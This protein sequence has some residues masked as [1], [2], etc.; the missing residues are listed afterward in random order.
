MPVT[1]IVGAVLGA[2]MMALIIKLLQTIEV[3]GVLSLLNARF[4]KY[5][6]FLNLIFA[7]FDFPSILPKDLIVPDPLKRT[8]KNRLKTSE[9]ISDKFDNMYILSNKPDLAMPYIMVWIIYA[10]GSMSCWCG[11]PW[12]GV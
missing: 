10:I 2:Q 11:C 8:Q 5:V 6:A 12:L 9:K 4:G 3:L 7:S 1:T